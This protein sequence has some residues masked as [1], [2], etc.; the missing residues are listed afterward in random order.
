MGS[1]RKGR[2]IGQT[3]SSRTVKVYDNKFPLRMIPNNRKPNPDDFHKFTDCVF[4]PIFSVD[5]ETLIHSDPPKRKSKGVS[6]PELEYEVESIKKTRV[7]KGKRQYLVKW[8]DCSNKCN[9]WVNVEDM[10]CD[11][12]INEFESQ[13]A[14]AGLKIKRQSLQF[15]EEVNRHAPL[16]FGPNDCHAKTVVFRLMC[17]QRLEG[18]VHDYL[19]GYKTEV[20]NVLS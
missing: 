1:Y 13:T 10:S 9:T 15:E 12:M 20:C 5:S 17:R 3:V 6:K 18:T 7:Y 11:D 4:N 14:L 16:L 2:L 8:K 19:P